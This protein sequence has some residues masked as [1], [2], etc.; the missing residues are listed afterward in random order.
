MHRHRALA[1]ALST[2]ALC[3]VATAAQADDAAHLTADERAELVA[4]LADSRAHVEELVASTPADSWAT[5][6]ADGGWSVAEVVEHLIL[7]EPAIRGLASQALAAEPTAE[8]QETAAMTIA[9]LSAR[10][11]DRSQQFQ[12]PDPLQ[13]QGGMARDE[14]LRR[15]S[16]ERAVT[17]DL[18]RTL[19]G[20]VKMHISTGPPGTM[21]VAHWLTLVGAHTERHAAQIEE[22]LA[23]L[24]GEPAATGSR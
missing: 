16:G 7:A 12:A 21:N 11:T 14:A 17:L 2:A 19:T 15:F 3:L 18:V 4:L 23:E 20:P 13:P 10:V 8:W 5:K 24:A 1:A 9:A 6:P 22:V